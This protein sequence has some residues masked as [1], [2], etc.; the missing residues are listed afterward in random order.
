MRADSEVLH[1]STTSFK[2]EL[3][4]DSIVALM[5]GCRAFEGADMLDEAAREGIGIRE[6]GIWNGC[7][8]LLCVG[9]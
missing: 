5:V 4:F 3:D 2:E 8:G 1:A 9:L 7:L 6:T